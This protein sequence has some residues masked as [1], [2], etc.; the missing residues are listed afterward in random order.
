MFHVQKENQLV[1]GG[2]IYKVTEE[3]ATYN[4]LFLFHI[5]SK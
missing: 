4:D 2:D 5:Q 1:K 3:R